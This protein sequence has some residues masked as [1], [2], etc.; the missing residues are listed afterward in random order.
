MII[1][2]TAT[3]RAGKEKATGVDVLITPLHIIPTVLLFTTHPFAAQKSAV[4]C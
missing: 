2:R 4:R 3:A 1:T